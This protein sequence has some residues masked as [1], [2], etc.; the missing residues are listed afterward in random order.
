[1][2]PSFKDYALLALAIASLVFFG[3]AN[4]LPEDFEWDWAQVGIFVIFYAGIG[5]AIVAGMMRDKK[6]TP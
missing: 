3:F 6:P 2:K 4:K 1:M 5:T